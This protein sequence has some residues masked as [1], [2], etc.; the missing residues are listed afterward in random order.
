[1]TKKRIKIFI[2]ELPRLSIALTLIAITVGLIIAFFLWCLDFVIHQRFSHPYLLYLLPLAGV[3]IYFLYQQAGKSI[4]KG[5]DLI[6][7]EIYKPNQGIPKR[8][9]LLV[10]VTTLITHLF[11]GSAG[12]E[13]TAVQIGASIAC[14]FGQW[15]K[16]DSRTMLISG[17]AAGF[18]AV[19]GTPFAGA[20]FAV[21]ILQV[22]RTNYKTFLPA[23][24]AALIADKTVKTLQIP[25]TYYSID[26]HKPYAINFIQKYFYVEPSLVF[27]IIIASIF[28]GLAA[29]FFS[30]LTK[31]IKSLAQK[32]IKKKWLIPAIGGVIII[33]LTI[34]NGKPDYLSLGVDPEYQGA[35][36][37]QSA[38]QEDG[39][40]TWSWFWKTLYTGVT[41]GTGFKG[42][43]VTPL[44]YIG[45]T[46]G[47][48]LS[49][50]LNAPVS[51]FAALGFIAVFSG[52][53]NTPLASSIMGAE[54]FG[55][56]HIILYLIACYIAYLFSGHQSIYGAQLI[57]K[58]KRIYLICNQIWNTIKKTF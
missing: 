35:T 4:E 38:F 27:K 15:L 16:I 29:F 49:F 19:F 23:I 7:A 56:E 32:I 1:M 39:A 57:Y 43:E 18:G 9:G 44:F 2:S 20:I 33:V 37:V 17:V 10:L 45:A 3:F 14:F 47:N 51:L 12:R 52:A 25:H 28:F 36:T 41:I 54:I 42:G 58:K 48:T 40:T 46:L 34:V 5:N 13:G 24:I 6:I 30:F 50:F 26:Y 8:M 55:K 22:R 53:T 21:E 11:G 31:H